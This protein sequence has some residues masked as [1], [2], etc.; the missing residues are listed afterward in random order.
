MVTIQI[1][2]EK[3]RFY[4]FMNIK[5]LDDIEIYNPRNWLRAIKIL[6]A[7]IAE[8]EIRNKSLEKRL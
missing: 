1:Y 3:E 5:N 8:E 6:D 2:E 7:K 4:E